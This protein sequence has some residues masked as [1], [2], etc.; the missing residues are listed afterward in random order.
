M[1]IKFRK[2]VEG[3]TGKKPEGLRLGLAQVKSP[4]TIVSSQSSANP[5]EVQMSY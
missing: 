3:Y 4:K 1:V 2:E 5:R